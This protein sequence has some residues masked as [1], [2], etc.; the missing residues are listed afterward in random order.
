M[1]NIAPHFHTKKALFSQDIA[2]QQSSIKGFRGRR[3]GT[4]RQNF[5]IIEK[6][7]H[8][9]KIL[10]KHYLDKVTKFDKV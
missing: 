10:W 8:F 9:R 2:F 3:I 4:D 1:I 7:C 5:H 6:F